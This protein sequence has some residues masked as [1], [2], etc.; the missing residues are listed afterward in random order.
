MPV[1][2]RVVE[3]QL[4]NLGDFHRF[5]TS[6]EIRYLPEVLVEGERVYGVTSGFF[7]SKTWIIV[8][9]NM[10][11]IFLDK[12][13]F[14][15]LKQVDM[16]LSQIDSIS[17]KTGLLFGEIAVATAAGAKTI[18]SITKKDV[19]KIA[20]IISGL[21]HGHGEPPAPQA[22]ATDARPPADDL[23]SQFERLATLYEKG[24]LTEDEFHRSKARLL[25]L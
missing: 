11:L 3:E 20:S 7:E 8:I 12:G 14:F 10:R 25:D 24:A 18:G 5:F 23:V 15:G 17:H 13:M 6:K 1:D 2:R 9:T 22:A 4:K 16:P 19:V 21:I